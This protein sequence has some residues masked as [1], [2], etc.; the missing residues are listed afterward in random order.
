MK[1]LPGLLIVAL[2]AMSSAGFAQAGVTASHMGARSSVS[3]T[4]SVP[5]TRN[6]EV[7][8]SYRVRA[9]R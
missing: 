1:T 2:L 8:C 7:V 9:G 4:F 5:V 3:V 6:G